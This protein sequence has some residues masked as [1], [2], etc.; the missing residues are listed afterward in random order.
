MEVSRIYSSAFTAYSSVRVIG[1][2]YRFRKG[3]VV[4]V[5]CKEAASYLNGVL[6]YGLGDIRNEWQGMRLVPGRNVITC[7][8]SSWAQGVEYEIRYRE[9]WL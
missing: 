3:D 2:A 4:T 7:Q 1:S 6:Q 5:D 9:A 8:A